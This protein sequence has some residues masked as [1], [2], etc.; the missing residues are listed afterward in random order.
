MSTGSQENGH[1]EQPIP[2]LLTPC[3]GVASCGGPARVWCP[4]C[5]R[6]YQ[7]DALELGVPARE[8]AI[9]TR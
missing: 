4:E 1:F 3:H 2:T 8:L 9:S 6:S 5:G 7:A